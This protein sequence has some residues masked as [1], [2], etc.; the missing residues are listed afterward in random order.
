[1]IVKKERLIPQQTL[2][3]AHIVRTLLSPSCVSLL[4][5]HLHGVSHHLAS[6]MPVTYFC[7]SFPNGFSA[8]TQLQGDLYGKRKSIAGPGK[9]EQ[10]FDIFCRHGGDLCQGD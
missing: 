8:D 3:E 9:G 4:Q 2:S 10:C 7:F 6:P 1:M 5:G